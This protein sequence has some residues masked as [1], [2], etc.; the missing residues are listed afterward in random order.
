MQ[1]IIEK[2]FLPD[3]RK[4][5]D[6]L[7]VKLEELVKKYPKALDEVRGLGLMIGIKISSNYVNMEIVTSLKDNGLLTVP[8]A[9]NV[10]RILPP[11]IINQGHIDESI[12]IIDQTLSQL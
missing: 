9:E 1:H 10:I 6:Y 2:D 3:V 8:A 5:S 11:L 4:N 12:K 7:T